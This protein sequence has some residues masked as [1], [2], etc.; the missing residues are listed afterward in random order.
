MATATSNYR[1]LSR[2]V[3]QSPYCVLSCAY[4]KSSGVE[5]GNIVE[6]YLA[7]FVIYTI[8]VLMK[9]VLLI[10]STN[11]ATKVKNGKQCILV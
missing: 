1:G 9:L 11:F 5:N 2:G 4:D 3:P 8:V 7:P 10:L 6:K